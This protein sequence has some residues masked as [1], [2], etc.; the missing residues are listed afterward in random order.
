MKHALRAGSLYSQA[1]ELKTDKPRDDW[2]SWKFMKT[3]TPSDKQTK[4]G[5]SEELVGWSRRYRN[6]ATQAF[7]VPQEEQSAAVKAFFKITDI[8]M[9]K[10]IGAEPVSQEWKDRFMDRAKNVNTPAAQAKF[11]SHRE[12]EWSLKT[13]YQQG[14]KAQ[15]GAL[16][17]K[18]DLA[19]KL[20]Q[21]QQKKQ[22]RSMGMRLF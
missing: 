7:N 10:M 2:A 22:T 18:N 1:S 13:I 11:E 5:L 16:P 3:V 19:K 15:T 14:S 20:I 8:E 6:Y 9:R 4:L 12:L 21:E 17:Q